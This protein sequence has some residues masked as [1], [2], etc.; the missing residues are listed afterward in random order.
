MEI[1]EEAKKRIEETDKE[2]EEK[3]SQEQPSKQRK[4]SYD[5]DEEAK[6]YAKEHELEAYADVRALQDAYKAGAKS[7]WDKLE[8]D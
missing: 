5:I 7:M 3:Y 1:T 6:A 4:P 2:I 8:G